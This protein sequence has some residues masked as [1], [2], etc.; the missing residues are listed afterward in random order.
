MDGNRTLEGSNL[1][2]VERILLQISITKTLLNSYVFLL[3]IVRYL[4][5]TE[6]V[7]LISERN[8]VMG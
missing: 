1:N 7:K 6:E 5:K 2:I 4:G 8:V 3:F